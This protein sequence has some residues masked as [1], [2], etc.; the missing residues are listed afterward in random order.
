MPRAAPSGRARGSRGP[1]R[2]SCMSRR[3]SSPRARERLAPGDPPARP[4]ASRERGGVARAARRG[5]R[6]RRPSGRAP[7][8][9]DDDRHAA[10]HRLDRDP[11]ELLRPRGVGSDGTA[12]T[13][14]AAVERGD[15][16]GCERAEEL[17]PVREARA[18]GEPAA[19]RAPAGPRPRCAAC[20]RGSRATA[21]R[22]T[23]E[24]L[25]GHE[26]TDEAH[27][28]AAPTVV[29]AHR[30]ASGDRAWSRARSEATCR[31][32]A[33][34]PAPGRRSPSPRRCAPPRRCTPD[35]GGAVAGRH[36]RATGTARGSA[37]EVLRGVEHV[38][39]RRCAAQRAKQQ[40]LGR[41]EG[42]RLLVEVDDVPPLAEGPPRAVGGRRRTGP[43]G[44]RGADAL[45]GSPRRGDG[46]RAPPSS[47]CARR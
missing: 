16:V 11:A 32:P 43:D 27:D 14:S 2:P 8:S 33:G 26:A 36:A 23:C 42:E 40:D 24:P 20:R 47:P 21:S 9:L 29:T 19:A 15:V 3:R 34:S 35:A 18:R 13:S 25:L 44:G 46:T 17:D 7:A 45:T 37:C 6:R 28:D 22:R 38:S 4:S 31:R 39:A 5:R 1:R 41:R 10:R 12:S 30:R